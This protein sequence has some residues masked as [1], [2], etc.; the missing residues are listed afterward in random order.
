[1]IQFTRTVLIACWLLVATTN[2]VSAKFAVAKNVRGTLSNKERFLTGRPLN[3]PQPLPTSLSVSSKIRG[4]GVMPDLKGIIISKQAADTFDT[5]K[6]QRRRLGKCKISSYPYFGCDPGQYKL[7]Y[8]LYYTCK[9]C[10]QGYYS[11]NCNTDHSCSKWGTCTAGKYQTNSPSTKTNR[12]CNGCSTGQY[13]NTNDATSCKSD[14]NAGSS[15]NSAKTACN[16]CSDGQYQNENDQ[17][18]CKDCSAGSSINNDKTACN[19]CS[20]GQ[21]QNENDQSICKSDC[22]AGSSINI[23]KTACTQCSTGQ[24]QDQNDQTGCKT[25]NTGKSPNPNQTGCT[26]CATGQYTS[27]GSC[28][29]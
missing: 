10:P 3:A 26:G 6:S 29:H 17:S 27:D 25:C 9:D 16:Q 1:M 4:A 15:I 21:Y 23:A 20:D 28:K 11:S 2:L 12:A 14:C 5:T 22:N 24:Y 8:H 19:Q 13:S 18:I 7:T